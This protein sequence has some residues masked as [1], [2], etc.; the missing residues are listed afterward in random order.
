MH[1]QKTVFVMIAIVAAMSVAIAPTTMSTAMALVAPS[2]DELPSK[3]NQRSI[4]VNFSATSLAETDYDDY[5]GELVIT[6]RPQQ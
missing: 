4:M 2:I 6:I 5:S 1:N 3:D